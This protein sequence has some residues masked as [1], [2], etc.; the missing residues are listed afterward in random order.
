MFCLLSN[1]HKDVELYHLCHNVLIFEVKLCDQEYLMLSRALKNILNG[2]S[3]LSTLEIILSVSSI[4]A[5]SVDR[6][7]RNPL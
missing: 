7:V 6:P 3:F 1:F 5:Y 4:V 2:I